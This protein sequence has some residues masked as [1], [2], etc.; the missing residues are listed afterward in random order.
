[1]TSRYRF[2]RKRPAPR[3]HYPHSEFAHYV[4]EALPAPPTLQDWSGAAKASLGNVYLND[5]LGDCVIA[6][7]YHVL[8]VETGNA[9]NLF[10]ATDAQI[11]ADYSAIGGYVPGKPSTDNGCDEETALNYWVNTGFTS[12]VKLAGWVAVDATSQTLCSQCLM[13]FENL[14]LG[15]ELPIAWADN[16]PSASGFVWDVAGPPDPNYGHCIIAY[17]YN[18][19]GV[20]IATWGLTGILTWAALAKYCVPNAGGACYTLITPAQ[21]KA[22]QQVTPGGVNWPNL[23]AYFDAIGGAVP[24]PLPG[25]GPTPAP[26]PPTPP[27]PTPTSTLITIDPANEVISLPAGWTSTPTRGTTIAVHPPMQTIY[28]PSGWSVN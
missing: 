28:Y 12:G 15:L 22:G 24:P 21:I 11:T 1:M 17:G 20:M 14:Y 2:G 13:L 9:G 18:S 23:V 19:Q 27:A 26:T 7:G 4:T 16:L 5:Q 10:V 6:G 3:P 25:P 8:G